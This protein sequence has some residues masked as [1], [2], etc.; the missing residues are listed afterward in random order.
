MIGYEKWKP[1]D[2]EKLYKNKYIWHTSNDP[3]E[4]AKANAENKNL[5]AIYGMTDEDDISM[6][7]LSYYRDIAERQKM[8]DDNKSSL[9]KNITN[10]AQNIDE[11]V[12]E[13]ARAL[14]NFSY[15]PSTDP[16]Y[17]SYVDMY[18]R[19]GQSAAKSTLNNL[20][21]ANMGRNSSYSAAATAQVQQA[22]AGKASEM[23]PT[24]A[25]QAYN[26]L[27]QQYGI[28]KDISDS[29]YN[30]QLNAYSTVANQEAQDIA[31]DIQ[32]INREKGKIELEYLPEQL[33]TDLESGKLAIELQKLNIESMTY[34]NRISAVAA[35]IQETYGMKLADAEYVAKQ[36][37]TELLRR[38][39]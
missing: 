4:R 34:E 3:N 38:Q 1:E 13:R 24:L 28:E 31:N 21:S 25:E 7:E 18:N 2:T 29:M 15:N 6:G 22:Y 35:L 14:E 36:L 30:R 39:V 16:A 19:Q 10:G 9:L 20:N 23:I 27:L 33:K 37:E 17:Q 5:R 8:Y 32:R 12:R 11:N 26:K